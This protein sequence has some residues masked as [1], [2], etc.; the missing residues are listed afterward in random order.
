[1]RRAGAGIA[2]RPGFRGAGRRAAG[3]FRVVILAGQSNAQGND[4]AV[5]LTNQS[6]LSA[7][8][9]VLFWYHI[10][11]NS[12]Q[13]LPQQSTQLSDLR[14]LGDWAY[15]MELTLG[16]TLDAAKRLED[17]VVI[18]KVAAGATGSGVW[19]PGVPGAQWVWVQNAWAGAVAAMRARDPDKTIVPTCVVWSQGE[20]DALSGGTTVA[21]YQTRLES[22]MAGFRS[23]TGR[24]DLYAQIVL[25]HPNWP[26]DAVGEP[27]V[28]QA[29]ENVVAAQANT[30]AINADAL[31]YYVSPSPK[32]GHYTG[33]ALMTQ[34]E[35][36]AA[37]I[38]ARGLM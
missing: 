19:L 29:Q 3:A 11:S 7:Y 38:I 1:M 5:Q 6:L 23:L 36:A 16:R 33:N 2:K 34:G 21:S 10:N 37:A 9:R 24:A 35:T 13:P 8:P 27:N 17:E 20:T 18:V 25:L 28:R 14:S 15:G 31:G 32:N 4:E 12:R 22:I 30:D 26:G